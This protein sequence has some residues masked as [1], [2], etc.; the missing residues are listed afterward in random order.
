MIIGTSIFINW[1]L[2]CEDIIAA[3]VR[4]GN[5][6]HPWSGKWRDGKKGI[7]EN[8]S[9][10][11]PFLS[12]DAVLISL[13]GGVNFTW[14][15]GGIF[16]ISLDFSPIAAFLLLFSLLSVR[17]IIMI[18]DNF[19]LSC[20]SVCFALM[21]SE[22]AI[23][24]EQPLSVGRCLLFGFLTA[25]ERSEFFNG[26]R[27]SD[28][29]TIVMRVAG[30]EREWKRYGKLTE[31]DNTKT[32]ENSESWKTWKLMRLKIGLL[33]FAMR[34]W[35]RIWINSPP[36]FAPWLSQ[37]PHQKCQKGIAHQGKMRFDAAKNTTR[38]TEQKCCAQF[39]QD[40][41]RLLNG[42]LSSLRWGSA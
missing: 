26:I 42:K 36:Q 37:Q 12:S 14:G 10:V 24:D 35:D 32:G 19:I 22:W 11:I 9:I 1:V 16:I 2:F 18:I 21:W 4:K 41:A 30:V 5:W 25:S 34:K 3:F 40:D 13:P 15:V 39:H 31:F 20:S 7:H 23:N 28:E 29:I 8:Y 33:M 38:T 6:A 17:R 27:C